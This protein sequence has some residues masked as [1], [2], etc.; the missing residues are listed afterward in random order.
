VTLDIKKCFD[1]PFNFVLSVEVL[2]R[3]TK[4]LP[5]YFFLGSWQVLLQAG[6]EF[7]SPLTNFSGSSPRCL[8]KPEIAALSSYQHWRISPLSLGMR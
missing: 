4:H 3:P 8:R 1:S 5:I 6:L 7:Y 2:M